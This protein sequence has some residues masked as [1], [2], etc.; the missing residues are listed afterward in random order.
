MNTN[1]RIGFGFDVHAFGPGS[2]ITLGGVIIPYQMGLTAHS[3]GDVVIHSLVDALLGASALGDIGQYFPDTDIRWKNQE[4]RF[5]LQ[6]T[7]QM[8]HEKK[9][10]ISNADITII[11]EAPKV[12]GY[13]E[14]IRTN[15][16]T[17][18]K[19]DITQVSIKASTTEKLGFIGRNEGIAATATVLI[20]GV[21]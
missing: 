6:A 17:E 9:W 3:D 14:T 10:S 1:L 19:I 13:R 15:L 18:M 20:Y 11:A 7:V 16:A 12:S 21:T 4:S 5:F 2:H 8:L